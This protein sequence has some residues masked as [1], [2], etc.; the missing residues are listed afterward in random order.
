M[1]FQDI[2]S[3]CIQIN[4][5]GTFPGPL[6]GSVGI[7]YPYHCDGWGSCDVLSDVQLPSPGYKYDSTTM[8]QCGDNGLKF[9]GSTGLTYGGG[10]FQYDMEA[11]VGWKAVNICH[12]YALDQDAP[13]G[14]ITIDSCE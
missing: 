6:A 13:P 14:H 12:R 11:T 7:Y 1:V 9:G 5:I 4:D 10:S 8:H 2:C 3:G